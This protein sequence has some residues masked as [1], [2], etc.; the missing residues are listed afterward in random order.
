MSDTL[1]AL[2]RALVLSGPKLA[3]A[4][5]LSGPKLALDFVLSGPKLALAFV[6]S[7]TVEDDEGGLAGCGA[8]GDGRRRCCSCGRS[9]C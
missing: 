3:L 4:F 5:V 8:A 2:A 6:L 7:A 1:S 9:F